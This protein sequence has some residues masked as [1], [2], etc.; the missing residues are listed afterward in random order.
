MANKFVFRKNLDIGGLEAETDAF[1]LETFTDKGDID[2]LKDTENGRS[3]IVGRTGSG[4]SAL[5]R[6]LESSEEKVTRINP[7][8]MSLRYLSNSDIIRYLKGLG[9]NLDL[10]YKVLW[11]HVFIVEFLKMHF[12]EDAYKDNSSMSLWLQSILN[13]RKKEAINYLRAYHTDFW[14]KTETRVRTVEE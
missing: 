1:L 4:K 8:S 3:I 12:G 2:I 5:L 9:I 13:P 6:Y 10:F 14:E 11:K 7:E